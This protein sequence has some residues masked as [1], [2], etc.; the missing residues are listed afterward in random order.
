MI[1][2][3]ELLIALCGS[4]EYDAY[5]RVKKVTMLL[6]RAARQV[7]ADDLGGEIQATGKQ[8]VR[9]SL[10]LWRVA[11]GDNSDNSTEQA[12]NDR[13]GARVVQVC[14]RPSNGAIN[15]EE[16]YRLHGQKVNWIQFLNR[17]RQELR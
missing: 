7:V 9:T 14:D 13:A 11:M 2:H 1:D 15:L 16:L 8:Y 5:V 10:G 17:L 3:R 4:Q 12:A 6:A